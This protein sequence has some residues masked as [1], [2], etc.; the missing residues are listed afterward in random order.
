MEEKIT[1]LEEKIDNLEVKID[2]I[3]TILNSELKEDCKKM[4]SHIDFIENIYSNVK[5][6]LGYFFDT[7]NYLKG[8]KQYCIEGD[9]TAI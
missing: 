7:L 6:P 9:N 3:Y 2:K 5:S 8:D 1:L 4:S